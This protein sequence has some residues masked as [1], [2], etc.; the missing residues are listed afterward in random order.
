VAEWSRRLSL[1]QGDRCHSMQGVV[2]SNPK[3][4]QT[5]NSNTNDI[6]TK[7]SRY[8]EQNSRDHF[9]DNRASGQAIKLWYPNRLPQN[10]LLNLI[11]QRIYWNVLEYSRT[12][13]NS[14][15]LDLKI[16]FGH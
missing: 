3:N 7:K 12:C 11:L 14:G 5:E 2:S 16:V 4:V 6:N 10:E 9:K 13:I 8:T 15:V 1:W